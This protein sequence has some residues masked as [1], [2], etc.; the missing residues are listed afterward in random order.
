MSQSNEFT[1]TNFDKEVLENDQPVLVDFW[2]PW[3]GPCRAVSAS[4][5][6]LARQFAGNV[7]VGKLNIDDNPIVSSRFAIHSIPAVLLFKDGMVV[8]SLFGAQPKERYE[9]AIVAVTA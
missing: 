8:E 7:M 2:A 9:H 1:D 5:E 4:I 3:C 6:Q